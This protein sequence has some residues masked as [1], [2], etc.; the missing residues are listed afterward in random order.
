M[1][2]EP[3]LLLCEAEDVPKSNSCI[4]LSAVYNERVKTSHSLLNFNKTNVATSSDKLSTHHESQLNK[5][6]C[7]QN[8]SG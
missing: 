1:E 7:C 2:A 3:P 8:D 4:C 5:T 6:D